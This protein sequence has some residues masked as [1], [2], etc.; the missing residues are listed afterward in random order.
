MKRR[1]Y[2]A[3]AAAS[4]VVGALSLITCGHPPSSDAPLVL[5]FTGAGTSAN[6]VQ[7]LQV[8]LTQMRVSY[9]PV[10]ARDL[11]RLTSA[12][13]RRSRLLIVP[14][15]DFLSM[16]A[17]LTSPTR[18]TVHA[19][20][21]DGL[22]YLG[23]CAGAF[24]AGQARYASFDLTPG[25]QFEFYAAARA[26]I[27]KTAVAIATPDGRVRDQYWEDGPHLSGWGAVVARYADGTPA[28]VE[29]RTGRGWV[30]LTG[31]HPEAPD[32]W[33][34]GLRFGTPTS[35]DQAYARVLIDAALHGTALPHFE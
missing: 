10:E 18:Q 7:A 29:G 27:R 20:V 28:V 19:A 17:S 21:Q 16:G 12:Q 32:S 23:I 14:G 26:G 9:T 34:Q 24:L 30:L 5:L 35:V 8:L 13:L 3:L 6:D 15:G 4:L 33:R 22:N 11:A 31:I 2:R 1:V 25:V